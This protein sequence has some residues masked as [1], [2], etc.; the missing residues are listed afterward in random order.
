[1]IDFDIKL[2]S[3][4]RHLRRKHGS[5]RILTAGEFLVLISGGQDVLLQLR[6]GW[7]IVTGR[8][9][10]GWDV[11]PVQRPFIGYHVTNSVDYAQYVHRT[12]EGPDPLYTQQLLAIRDQVLPPIIERLKQTITETEKYSQ[13]QQ[14]EPGVGISAVL[15]QAFT[16]ARRLRRLVRR[17]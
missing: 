13:P 5:R 2:Q 15:G 3:V 16:Q 11:E 9:I 10:A 6:E 7:P 17:R 1:M 8:S 12:G 14:A 4:E